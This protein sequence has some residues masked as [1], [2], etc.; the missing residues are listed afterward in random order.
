MSNQ[1]VLVF[2]YYFPPMGLSGVQ[3]VS[4]FM[5]YLPD[6]GWQPHV[7]TTGPTAYYAHDES[8]LTDLED[9]DI[10]IYRTE[11]K[12]PNSLLKDQGT[13]KM[14]REFV[15]KILRRLSDTFFIPDNKK[16]WAQQAL[17]VARDLVQQHEYEAIFVSGPPF[18]SMMAAATLSKETGI[19]LIVDYRDLWVGNQFHF[20]PTLWHSNKH[21]QLER[22]VLSVAS[23]VTVTNR[24]IKEHL[25]A[26][27][28]F[29]CSDEVAIIPHGYDPADF[30][31]V[32]PFPRE[33]SA[34]R[35]TYAGIFYDVVSPIPFFKA[36]KKVITENPTFKLDLQF[37]G[38]LRDE[39]KKAAKKYRI[40]G[41]ITD[42]GYCEHGDSVRH[43][44]SSDA[45]WMMVGNTRNADTISSAKLYEYMASRKPL[46]VS[47]P[48]GILRKD[49]QRYGAAWITEPDD[50]D[51]IA[52][53][54]VEMYTAWKQGR[55][56]KPNEDVIASH[57]RAH[58]TELLAKQFG[59]SA[60]VI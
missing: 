43:L 10:V 36:V 26:R 44:L 59:M 60:R 18:S 7:I 49:A 3:R 14:P 35:L 31:Q 4:K 15:R 58:L 12:D 53:S 19:P 13:I 42:H 17:A 9:R 5:K 48:D 16:A 24:R 11:G 52:T 21:Q 55:M 32:S 30:V 1:R 38:L 33:D 22:E 28:N 41:L 40:D 54:I 29:L 47:V 37:V 27:Y 23:R 6:V 46:L 20:Y 25:I 57:N 34:F 56:P 39:Y 8:L 45:L 2:A 50:V 51:A